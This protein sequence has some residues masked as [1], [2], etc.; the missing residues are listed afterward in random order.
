MN[1]TWHAAHR[2]SR[3]ATATE[4]LRWHLEHQKACGCRPLTATMRKKLEAAAREVPEIDP[5]FA[6]V[7]KAML[8]SAGVTYGGKGF[9]STALKL[10]GK[11]FAF[12]SSRGRFVAKLPRERVEALVEERVG[13][14]FEPGPGRVMKEW[15]EVDDR[16]AEWLALAREAHR[17][18]A[19]E[20]GVVRRR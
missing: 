7:V 2:L 19:G 10:R 9:G 6:P 18:V 1:A 4:R 16:P 12:V 13:R 20:K 15:L 3:K 11:L 17:F 8:R 5:R 14:P